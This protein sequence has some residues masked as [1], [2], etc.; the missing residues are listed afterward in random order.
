VIGCHRRVYVNGDLKEDVVESWPYTSVEQIETSSTLT[1]YGMKYEVVT[2]LEF[3]R[4]LIPR[5][6]TKP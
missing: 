1:M 2:R 3:D 6:V 5:E 4:P